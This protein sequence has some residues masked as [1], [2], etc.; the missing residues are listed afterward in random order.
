[1]STTS[2]TPS[3]IWIF[4]THATTDKG[5][6]EAVDVNV[7]I[8]SDGGSEPESEVNSQALT[9]FQLI[10]LLL[11]IGFQDEEE[12]ASEAPAAAAAA[13][14]ATTPTPVISSSRVLSTRSHA[15]LHHR[16]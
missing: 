6:D 3:L 2:H 5:D 1:M 14:T 7:R 16:E 10:Q 8:E 15:S 13:T 12:D 9:P 4:L 11:I